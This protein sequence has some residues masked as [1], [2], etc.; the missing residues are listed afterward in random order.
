MEPLEGLRTEIEEMVV[1]EMKL[2]PHL[3]GKFWT[4]WKR[5]G[6]WVLTK[7]LEVDKLRVPEAAG[8]GVGT[9]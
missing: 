4:L 6:R 8:E 7:P 2:I 3:D 9:P 5:P 1:G